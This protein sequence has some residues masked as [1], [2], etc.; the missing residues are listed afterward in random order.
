VNRL[1]RAGRLLARFE[2]FILAVLLTGM[3]VLAAAQIFSRNLF[4]V[5]LTWG[6]PLLRVLVL[7]LT[8][9]GAMAATREG[10]HIR[11]DTLS[12]FLPERGERIARRVTDLFGAVVCALLAWHS[13]RFVH[14]DWQDGLELFAGVPSWSAELIMPLGF[15]VMALRFLIRAVAG[16][17]RGKGGP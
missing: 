2:D 12:R 10:H 15:G 6:E 11:I 8:L 7:W 9:L 13:G 4:S 3:I 1:H 17:A 16:E 14:G 5:G